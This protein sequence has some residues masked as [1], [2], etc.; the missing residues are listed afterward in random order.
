MFKTFKTQ[1]YS[2]IVSVW[3]NPLNESYIG[4]L[5]NRNKF[6]M[7]NLLLEYDYEAEDEEKFI[8]MKDF[9]LDINQASE[10]E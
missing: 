8:L 1:D 6:V 10:R 4:I 7:I 9:N 2:H 5:D 3:V